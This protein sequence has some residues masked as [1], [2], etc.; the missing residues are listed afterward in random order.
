MKSAVWSLVIVLVLAATSAQAASGTTLLRPFMTFEGERASGPKA[1][2]PIVGDTHDFWVWDLTVMPPADVQVTATC[3][4]VSDHAYVFVED[5]AWNDTMT[6]A[7]VDAVL[8]AWDEESPA[9]SIDPEQGV[10]DIE[11]ELYGAPPDV[12]GWPGIVLLYYDMGCFAGTCFDGFYRYDD[13]LAVPHS[14]EMDMLHLAAANEAPGEPYMLGVTAHEFNHMLQMTYD[15]DEYM[16][17]SEALAEAAMIVTGYDTDIAWLTSFLNTPGVSFFNDDQSMHYGAALLLGTYLFEAGG[18]DLLTAVTEDPNDGENSLDDQ[19]SE[20]GVAGGYS[21]FF[22][23]MAA[24]IVADHLVD[25]GRA[26]ADGRFHYDALTIGEPPFDSAVECAKDGLECVWTPDLDAGTMAEIALDN[27]SAAGTLYVAAE[28]DQDEALEGALIAVTATDVTVTRLLADDGAWPEQ[29]VETAGLELLAVVL[30]NP[31]YAPA[32]AT[33]TVTGDGAADD[34]AD[35][36]ASS[37]DDAGDDDF[38]D[39]ASG[40]DDDDDDDSGCGCA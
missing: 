28:L 13:Q 24:A 37:D 27:V 38:A 9:G 10:Y 16:W 33:I 34:D 6:Q 14:N 29:T 32:S 18:A 11:T 20:L 2:A 15:Q 22:G 35:D 12:D 30:A 26:D 21:E 7:D 8:A 39:D 1:A 5:T 31:T 17:L 4:G 25:A 36:D 3:R 40:D 23:D 19:V